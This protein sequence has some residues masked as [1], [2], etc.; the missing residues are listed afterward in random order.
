MSATVQARACC[1]V[2]LAG[3]TLDIWPLGLFSDGARTVNLAIDAEVRVDLVPRSA[4]YLVTQGESR[5]E[6]ADLEALRR[7]PETSLIGEVAAHLDLPPVEIAVRSDSPRGGGLGASSALT[8]A[9]LAAGHT[10]RGD[11]VPAAA[12]LAAVGRDIEARLMR[13][14]TGSQ[15][16]YP[17]CLGGALEIRY[18]AGGDRVRPL[19]VDL[20][21]LGRSL[22]VA[23]TG[24]S[25]FSAGNNWRVVRARLDGDARVGEAFEGIAAA[26]AAMPEA[27]EGG[28]L[29]R[30]G[31]LM[32][33][34]WACRRSLA[35]GITTPG[36][37]LLLERAAA[38]GAWGGKACGAGGG[39]SIAL[40]APAAARA[41][42]VEA[43]TAAG[44]RV[45]PVRP[46]GEPL[47][48]SVDGRRSVG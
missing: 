46:S 21:E 3:G 32:N 43:V 22:V 39:G 1:R 33:R 27:L 14:P 19:A 45:L 48:V 31:E 42:V 29:E 38:A 16:H 6:A 37:E 20:A 35:E 47:R 18:V 9:L 12:R 36:I 23:Y 25:H 13:L 30:V 41:A 8:V 10:L 4:G 2:D 5:V 15:D 28:R 44:A 11:T 40:V 7:E 24:Q 17:A 26:A 34:E